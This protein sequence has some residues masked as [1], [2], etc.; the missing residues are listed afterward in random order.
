MIHYVCV[1]TESILYLPYLKQLLPELV[2]LG[3]GMKWRGFIMKYELIIEYLESLKDDDIICF[4]DAYDVL[5][6]KNIIKLERK[7]IKF[8]KK[9]PNVKM[10]VGGGVTQNSIQEFFNDVV[11][12][13][14]KINSGTYIGYVKNIKHILLFILQQNNIQDDQVE[15]IKY[16]KQNPNDIYCDIKHNFFYVIST[17]LQQIKLNNKKCSFIHANGNGCLEN[18][19]LQHHNIQIDTSVTFNNYIIHFYKIIKKFYIYKTSITQKL[20]ESISSTIINIS[21]S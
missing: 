16:A 3:M 15:L 12:D 13:N 10:I 19:L 7:F 18:F 9:H 2:V 4:V 20:V 5:P 11:F 6:T 14:S 8:S 21:K 1:A 17:P